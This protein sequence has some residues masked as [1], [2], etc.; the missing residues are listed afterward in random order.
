MAGFIQNSTYGISNHYKS[1]VKNYKLGIHLE[2]I[3]FSGYTII[4]D[5]FGDLLIE[6]AKKKLDVIS[7]IQSEENKENG[8]NFEQDN[9]NVRCPLAYDELF[10]NFST[11]KIILTLLNELLGNNYIL[12][13]QN[14]IIN[15]PVVKQYQ[16]RWHRD[17]NYQHWLCSEAL[18]I[19]F[20]VL[21][22]DFKIENGCTWVVPSS[23]LR[24]EFPTEEYIKKHEVPLLGKAGSVAII[25]AM[26]F[27][28]SGIN[29][30]NDKIRRGLNH[31][32]GRPFLSQQIDIP[33]FLSNKSQ[34]SYINDEFLSKYLG[35]KWNPSPDVISWRKNRI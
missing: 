30:T 7:N 2:E 31:V 22:D 4:P 28:R 5:V 17:L 33:K 35:Y 21:L 27:H 19:N 10:L 32:V 20:L 11:N 18:A 29:Q 26:L 13:M 1:N 8:V 12:L 3:Y 25:N 9:D 16:T 24:S 34:K 6:Q 23:H 15:K 14:G